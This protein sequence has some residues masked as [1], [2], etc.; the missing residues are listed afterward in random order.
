MIDLPNRGFTLIELVITVAIVGI[1]AMTAMPIIE[2]TVKRQK[3]TDLR[4]A[5]RQIRAG[6]DA[7]KRAV[8][9]GKVEKKVDESGYPRRLEDLDQG[10]ENIQDPNKTKLYFLRRMPRDPFSDDPAL[11]AAQTW[12]RRSYASPPDAPLAGVDVFDVY[13][14]SGGVGL[15]GTPYREW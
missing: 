1:L 11:T 3:E 4:A 7:Y 13:S 14:L 2:V 12:G 15:N 10:V 9:E 8:D 5:L 6:I